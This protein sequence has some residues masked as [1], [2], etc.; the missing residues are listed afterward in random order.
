MYHNLFNES[1]PNRYSFLSP[2]QMFYLLETVLQWAHLYIH[3]CIF[4]WVYLKDKFLAV[5]LLGQK[6]CAFKI[7]K[8]SFYYEINHKYRKPNQLQ[9]LMDCYKT[10]TLLTITQIK[11]QTITHIRSPPNG[12]WSQLP[13]SLKLIV[14]LTSVETTFFYFFYGFTTQ[15]ASIN[16]IL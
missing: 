15:V 5:E 4:W 1:L 16:M 2:P 8:A 12:L 10:S 9:S 11:K 14:V 7:L 6:I 13:P 3:L